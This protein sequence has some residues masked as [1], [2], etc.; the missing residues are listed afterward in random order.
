MLYVIG[1]ELCSPEANEL[2]SD[3]NSGNSEIWCINNKIPK[4]IKE[5]DEEEEKT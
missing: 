1:I 5:E 2:M 3:C 4:W